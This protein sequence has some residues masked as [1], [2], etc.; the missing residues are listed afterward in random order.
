VARG[1]RVDRGA[2][3][4][5]CGNSGNSTEPHVHVQAMDRPA[6]W[7]AKGRPLLIDGRQPPRNGEVLGSVAA[8]DFLGEGRR[9]F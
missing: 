5:A 2:L 9:E 8:R 7:F 1:D 4:A 3:I 6:L